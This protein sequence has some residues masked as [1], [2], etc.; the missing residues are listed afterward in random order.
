M[1]NFD[2]FRARMRNEENCKRKFETS[3]ITDGAAPIVIHI[4]RLEEDR[5]ATMV[6]T[7]T[8]GPDSAIVFTPKQV[9]REQDL[10]KKDYYTWD[11]KMFFVYE[12]VLIARNVGYIKQKAYQC[13]AKVHVLDN[14]E[15]DEWGGYFISS[16][17]SYVDTEFQQKLN[18]SDK[19]KPVL[20]M[21]ATDWIAVGVKI[22]VG[23]KPWK[24]VDYDAITNPGIV[25]MSLERDFFKK[26]YDMVDAAEAILHAGVN[27]TLET[28]EGYFI[29]SSPLIIK[30]KTAEKVVFE[31]P[32]G[33]E[34]VTIT[35]KQNDQLKEKTYKVVM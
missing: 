7:D 22:E 25:Y 11:D 17:R 1:S 28:Q 12:N 9:D 18:V 10:L 24:I 23:G 14:D 30:S 20:I 16:L 35:V 33:I 3:F 21:P 29:S 19:E 5:D 31:V 8:E 2:L 6:F 4:L 32:Y 26:G 13:N 34:L 27:N 15:C